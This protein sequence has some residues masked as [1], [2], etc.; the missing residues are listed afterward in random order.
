MVR[1]SRLS[2]YVVAEV[3]LYTVLAGCLAA[4]VVL[5]PNVL[6]QVD[7]FAVVGMTVADLASAFGWVLLLVASYVLPI[8]F[9]F[10]LLLAMGRLHAD[11]E[12]LAMRACGLS[13]FA[14]VRP[15]IA[16]GLLFSLLS[17]VVSIGFEHR[18]WKQL[19]AIRRQVLSRGAVIEPGRFQRFGA[20]TVLAQDRLEGGEFVGVMI[21]D[22][23]SASNSLLIFAESA[24]YS[25]DAESGMIRL[26]L[27]DG[28]LRMEAYPNDEI[29]EHRISFEEFEYAFPA[30]GLV[31]GRWRFRPNQLSVTDLISVANAKNRSEVEFPLKYRRLRH[32]S[33]HLQR[34]FAVPVTPFLFSIIGVP[35][36]I[37]GFVGSRAK[38]VLAA[39]V[40]LGGYYA[41]F[42][43]CY[44]G[45]R[46]GYFPPAPAIWFPNALVLVAGT[47]LLFLA[48]RSHR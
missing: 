41:L 5:I 42:I 20:R 21:S 13:V 2:R 25:F 9:V 28:D 22:Y 48:A 18:A 8:A 31:G 29:K 4:P 33:S 46:S 1:L 26:L 40:L 14:L 19:E 35:L 11:G 39:L 43:F 12:I 17:A 16:V 23:T 36:A 30:P 3:I 27:V 24:Q 10:G 6:E 15:A 45:A 34:L 47:A 37:F 7:R 38:G 44:D 32:Y